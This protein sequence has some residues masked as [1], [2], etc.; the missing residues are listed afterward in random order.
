MFKILLIEDDAETRILV[1][2]LLEAAGM[3]VDT[4][5]SGEKGVQAVKDG[6]FDCVLVDL[7]MPDMDGFETIKLL[8]SLDDKSSI[9][10]AV[11]SA[12]SDKESRVNALNAGADRYMVKPFHAEQ[13]IRMIQSLIKEKNG[14]L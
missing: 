14:D 1:K 5:W 4:V 7:M 2:K 9:P 12:K 3:S 8:K 13:L 10:I 11:L 6:H